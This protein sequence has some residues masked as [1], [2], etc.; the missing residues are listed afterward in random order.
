MKKYLAIPLALAAI[1]A[2]APQH[3]QGPPN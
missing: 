1:A 3:T 2:A